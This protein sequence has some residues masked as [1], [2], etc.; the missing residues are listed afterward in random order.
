[1]H[2]NSRSYFGHILIAN[3][4]E[5]QTLL[6]H[7]YFTNFES[8]CGAVSPFDFNGFVLAITNF[9]SLLFERLLT[10]LFDTYSILLFSNVQ[11]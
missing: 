2:P 1:M 6:S 9:D 10:F 7:Q 3:T 8:K 5:H 4:G 11:R